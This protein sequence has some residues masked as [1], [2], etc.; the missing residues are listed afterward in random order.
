MSL[1]FL[2]DDDNHVDRD[3]HLR[4]LIVVGNGLDLYC[5]LKS[6]FSDFFSPRIDL[7]RTIEYQA[8]RGVP[9]WED[10]LINNNLT[11]W[12][13]VLE[14]CAVDKVKSK[15]WSD[16]E[17]V[18]A[19]WVTPEKIDKDKGVVVENKHFRKV[20]NTLNATSFGYRTENRFTEREVARLLQYKYGQDSWSHEVLLDKLLVELH[21]LENEFATYM[22][23]AV[24]RAEGYSEK[25]RQV[26]HDVVFNELEGRQSQSL[27]TS[28][29][30]FNY[31]IP[32]EFFRS[33][34][35][36]LI[37]HYANV[38]GNL[39]SEI[40]IGID[41]TGHMDD[42]SVAQFTKTYRV[43]GIGSSAVKG[44][45][46]SG[47]GARSGSATALMKFVGHSL[48]KADYSYFQSLFD[49]V[50][51]Y[52]G[53]TRL[54]FYHM[55]HGGDSFD[56]ACSHSKKSVMDSVV[57]LLTE[58]GE[59]LDNADHGRN[60]IHKLLLEGRLAVKLIPEAETMWEEANRS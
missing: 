55:P 37:D 39:H 32:S 8:S 23:D 10:Y 33:E 56:A 38:H 26:F 27:E 46:Y 12:D 16:I 25:Y 43:M 14:I 53:D 30:N 44:L 59:T 18:I 47:Q 20:L 13:I 35:F 7:L 17:A 41:A 9:G 48:N 49:T 34:S 28:I 54:V 40:V 2:L 60:L 6:R 45:V 29:L 50:D 22:V 57:K 15:N 21:E 36:G 3:R 42:P 58:Y 5:D 52:G 4:Q 19:N 1:N 51:L 24:K 31:T 11:A